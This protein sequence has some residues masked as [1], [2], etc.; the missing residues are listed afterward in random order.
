MKKHMLAM[1]CACAHVLKE[2][3]SMQGRSYFAFLKVKV[4]C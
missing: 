4:L 3:V 1:E 2:I